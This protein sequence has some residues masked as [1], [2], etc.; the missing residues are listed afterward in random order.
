M[1][2][3]AVH[4]AIITNPKTRSR[5]ERSIMQRSFKTYGAEISAQLH[6]H[7]QKLPSDNRGPTGWKG[8]KTTRDSIHTFTKS[9]GQLVG[10]HELCKG[11]WLLKTNDDPRA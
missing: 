6:R 5:P 3:L 11:N 4:C 9:Y 7:R 2:N 10:F 8:L 1:R